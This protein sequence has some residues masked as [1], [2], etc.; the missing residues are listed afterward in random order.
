[1]IYTPLLLPLWLQASSL[2]EL[3]LRAPSASSLLPP[4][5]PS[6]SSRRELPNVSSL[7]ELP[8]D[9]LAPLHHYQSYIFFFSFFLQTKHKHDM[10]C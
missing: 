7:C 1:M 2:C 8:R 10:P 4:R 5:A 3:P 9:L 6:A